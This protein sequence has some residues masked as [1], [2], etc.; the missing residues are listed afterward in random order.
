[1]ANTNSRQ[2]PRYVSNENPLHSPRI[3]A[4]RCLDILYVPNGYKSCSLNS[5]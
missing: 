1:L 3:L 2:R 5:Y 4:S